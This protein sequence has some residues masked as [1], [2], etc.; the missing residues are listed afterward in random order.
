MSKLFVVEGSKIRV[1]E[2]KLIENEALLQDVVERFPEV[3]ALEDLGV[4]EPFIVIGREVPTKAGNIDVLCIDGDGVLTVIE[5]KLARNSQ[6]RREVV[7]QILEYVAQLSKW[8]AHDVVQTANKYL[9]SADIKNGEK[10]R[11]FLDLLDLEDKDE[12]EP[13][14]M[15]L[16]DK[17]ENNL[18][19]GN[20]KLII[21]SDSIPNTLKDTITFIN[22]FSNFDIYVLQIQSFQKDHMQIFAPTI[23]GF[24]HK[25]AG[26]ITSE[27]IQWDEEK[28]FKSIS[29]FNP[30]VVQSI[31]K[32]YEFTQKNAASIKWGTGKIYSSFSYT[33][34]SVQK[35][36]NI[37]TVSNQG[38]SGII[39][40]YFGVMKGIIS[41]EELNAFRELLNELPNVD[42]HEDLV[43]EGKYPSIPVKSIIEQDNFDLF[44][45]GVLKLQ[46]LTNTSVR[47]S[48]LN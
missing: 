24:T 2:Q 26:G 33:V 45:S 25:L 31:R 23:F 41:N 17:I 9:G 39:F 47:V 43:D 32:L 7:G 12:T 44:T 8:R 40:I 37:F 3:I 14:F 19:K 18:R 30:E 13:F 4:T 36:F 42:L 21:V 28:F 1:L 27:R 15:D 22:S 11:T 20:I 10:K 48:K 34:D 38:N 6:I 35:K 46:G 16:Y 29:S 5:T